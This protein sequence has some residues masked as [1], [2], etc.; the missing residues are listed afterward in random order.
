MVR[1]VLT[2]LRRQRALS[3]T[4]LVSDEAKAEVTKYL[5][6]K[7]AYYNPDGTL[8][9]G[10]NNHIVKLVLYSFTRGLVGK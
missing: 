4:A 7:H 10:V 8:K 2:T 9:Y 1:V 5:N 3:L 6:S